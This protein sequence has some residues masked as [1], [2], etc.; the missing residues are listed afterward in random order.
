MFCLLVSSSKEEKRGVGVLAR[1]LTLPSREVGLLLD[2]IDPEVWVSHLLRSIK[3]GKYLWIL[4][5]K[6]GRL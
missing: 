5:Y 3:Y 2:N 1:S 4:G 6:K